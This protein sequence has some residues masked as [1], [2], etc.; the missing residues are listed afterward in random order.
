MKGWGEGV[1]GETGCG[2]ARQSRA[3]AFP[4]GSTMSI[5]TWMG[6]TVTAYVEQR[7]TWWDE[8]LATLLCGTCSCAFRR[9]SERTRAAW[10][11][12]ALRGEERLPVLRIS[13]PHCCSTHTLLPDFLTPYHRYRTPVREAVVTHVQPAPPCCAQT[14]TRW[15]R[16]VKARVPT[17]IQYVTS[18]LLTEAQALGARRCGVSPVSSTACRGCV[19]CDCWWNRRANRLQPRACLAGS[20]VNSDST[21]R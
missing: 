20:T 5:L 15:T 17:A 11:D 10:S 18:W 9:H 3:C 4:P 12:F 8:A 6:A 13:C 14:I 7:Y 1:C 21:K 2:D 16:A 19:G